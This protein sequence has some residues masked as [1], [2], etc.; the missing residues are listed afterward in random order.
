MEK[1]NQNKRF[2]ELA[3]KV[4]TLSET[5][6]GKLKGGFSAFSANVPISDPTNV[7]VDVASGHTC[8]C[9]CS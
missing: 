4:Q 1:K 2:Q 8:A 3:K 5:Q 6:K 7:N 9:A